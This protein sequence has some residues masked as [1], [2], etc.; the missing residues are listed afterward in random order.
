MLAAEAAT[1]LKL[2]ASRLAK[3]LRWWW[4]QAATAE[5]WL[6]RAFPMEAEEG[7]AMETIANMARK[8]EE[9]LH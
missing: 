7:A 4:A 2:S 6:T 5:M 1:P 3:P 9:G 8:E